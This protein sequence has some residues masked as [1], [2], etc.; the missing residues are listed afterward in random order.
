MGRGGWWSLKV[1]H[2]KGVRKGVGTLVTWEHGSSG[3]FGECA[4]CPLVFLPEVRSLQGRAH[5]SAPKDERNLRNDS[6]QPG[7]L[8]EIKGF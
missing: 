4:G 6:L 3:I 5:S 7:L 2:E 1:K 8:D